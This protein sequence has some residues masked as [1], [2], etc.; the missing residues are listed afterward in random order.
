MTNIYL[1]LKKKLKMDN[2]VMSTLKLI[3][4]WI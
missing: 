3:I 2:M 4:D 1:L